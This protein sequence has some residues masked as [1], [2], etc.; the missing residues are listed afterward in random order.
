[1]LTAHEL[2]QLAARKLA[3]AKAIQGTGEGG[4]LTDAEQ[5]QFNA[6]LEEHDRL[7][8]QAESRE[9]LENAE[10][11]ADTPVNK[12]PAQQTITNPRDRIEDKPWDSLGEQMLAIR[13]AYMAGG[14]VDPRLK[15]AATGASEGVPSDGG[16]L[17][18]RPFAEE[19][20]TRIH[21]AGQLASRC[22][23]MSIGANANGL[24]L[25]LVDETSRANGSRWGGVQVYWTDEAEEMTASKPKLRTLDLALHKL[26]GLFY[27]TDELLQDATAMSGYAEMAMTEEFAVKLDD[28]ILNGAGGPTPLGIM[29][30]GA[31]VTVSK[32][33]G[34]APDTFVFENAN[35]MRARLWARSRP[36]SAWFYNQDVEPQLPLMNVSVGT[37][38][39]AV[40]QPA[41]GAADAPL[42]RLLGRP[43]IPIEQAKTLGDLGDI[44][45]LDLSE[46]LLIEKGG[47]QSAMSIHVEFKSNQTV[48][49][50]VYRV[51]GAPL[52]NAA[53]T[54]MNGTNKVSPFVALE[55]R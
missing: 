14:T 36:N 31:L 25:R 43:M 11:L 26:T 16:F 9:R 54:P 40:Y 38:G 29:N 33:A 47:V 42:D 2:R 50:W 22:R 4:V 34:Q 52:W 5:Q 20:M 39:T 13:N 8:A 49:R 3:E 1:M 35:N 12:V 45:L 27:A 44:V 24:K 17:V 41:G 55:A 15:N 19:L 21:D 7:K 46:Y 48:F 23:R 51:N 53:L 32:E 37:G 18:D 6:L 28:A 30:C 10:A